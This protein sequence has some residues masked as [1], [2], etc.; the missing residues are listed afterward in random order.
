VSKHQ[1][2]KT[3]AV[4]L[5]LAIV[6]FTLCLSAHSDGREGRMSSSSS[7]SFGASKGGA[8]SV[9]QNPADAGTSTACVNLYTGQ[10][11]E[12]FP[13]ISLPGRVGT[14]ISLSLDYNGNVSRQVKAEN[15]ISQASDFGLGFTLGTEAIVADH[16]GTADIIDDEYRLVSGSSMVRL[17]SRGEGT[18]ITEDGRPWVITRS[19]ARAPFHSFSLPVCAIGWTIV[20]E[21]GSVYKYGDFDSTFTNRNATHYLLRFGTFVGP[22]YTP[23]D[24]IHAVQW[25]LSSMQSSADPT[26]RVL[27]SYTQEV[28]R[29]QIGRTTMGNQSTFAYTSASHLSY[30]LTPDGNRVDLYYSARSD[31]TPFYGPENYEMFSTSKCDSILAKHGSGSVLARILLGYS[32]L[33]SS[34]DANLG[35]P[36]QKLILTSICNGSTTDTSKQ[37][38]LRFDY[39]SDDT[40]QSMGSISRIIYPSGGVKEIDYGQ[41]SAATSFARLDN[42]LVS[43]ASTATPKLQSNW[44]AGNLTVAHVSDSTWRLAIWDGYWKAQDIKASAGWGDRAGVSADGWAVVPTTGNSLIICRWKG[45]YWQLDTLPNCWVRIQ[46]AFP[47][48]GKDGFVL[49][50]G[51]A[52]DNQSQY[53]SAYFF[54]WDGLRWRHWLAD[55]ISYLGDRW[56]IRSV[57]VKNDAFLISRSFQVDDDP[58]YQSEVIWGHIQGHFPN[59]TISVQTYWEPENDYIIGGN[60]SLGPDYVAWLHRDS[61][62]FVKWSGTA[63]SAP[64]WYGAGNMS[65]AMGSTPRGPVAQRWGAPS[66]NVLEGI[67]PCSGTPGYQVKTQLLSCTGIPVQDYWVGQLFGSRIGLGIWYVNGGSD[68]GNHQIEIWRAT[69]TGWM[70]SNCVIGG[71][72]ASS[73]D[74][75][76]FD[77]SYAFGPKYAGGEAY[78]VRARKYVGFG[79]ESNGWSN[80]TFSLTTRRRHDFAAGDLMFMCRTGSSAHF[81]SSQIYLSNR[82]YFGESYHPRTVAAYTSSDT[83]LLEYAVSGTQ[84][85]M[86]ELFCDTVSIDYGHGTHFQFPTTGRWNLNTYQLFDTLVMGKA[87][88]PVVNAVKMYLYQTDPNPTI[89]SF[90]YSAGLLDAALTTPRFA[91]AKASTPYFASEGSPV[92]W[93][94]HRFYNDID[95][96]GFYNDT[97]YSVMPFPNLKDSLRYGIGN[98]GYRLDGH[99]YFSAYYNTSDSTRLLDS[100][101]SFYSLA[102]VGRDT[103]YDVYRTQLNSVW[104]QSDSLWTY[105]SF[106]YDSANGQPCQTSTRYLYPTPADW[107]L[108]DSTVYAY[109]SNDSMKTD[110]ALVQPSSQLKILRMGSVDSVLSRSGADYTRIKRWIPRHSYVYENPGQASG[111]RYSDSL[112]TGSASCDSYGNVIAQADALGTLHASKYDRYG[113]KVVA[114]A[115]NCYPDGFTVLDLEQ[116]TTWDGWHLDSTTVSWID[117]TQCF[118]GHK[119][120]RMKDLVGTTDWNLGPTRN[121][122]KAALTSKL[123]YF[124]GWVKTDTTVG[125]YCYPQD[126]TNHVPSGMSIKTRLFSSHDGTKW[127]RFEGVFDLTDIWAGI[128]HIMIQFVMED[129]P[130]SSFAYFDDFR[131]H[132]IV[133]SVASSVYDGATGQTLASAGANNVPTST[134][135]DGFARPVTSKNSYGQTL[136]TT[137]Y[138]LPAI[139]SVFRDSALVEDPYKDTVYRFDT[140]NAS[141]MVGYTLRLMEQAVPQ[142]GRACIF[143]N[144]VKIDSLVGSTDGNFV[145]NG[146]FF[147]ARGDVI[148]LMAASAIFSQRPDMI[149]TLWRYCA[150]LSYGKYIYNP[151][152]P[153]YT[154]VTSYH[155]GQTPDTLVTYLDSWGRQL[156]TRGSDSLGDSPHA[157]VSGIATYDARGRVLKS[158]LPYQD[159]VGQSGV[160]NYSPPSSAAAEAAA[161]YDGGTLHGPDAQG[162]PY[163]ENAYTVEFNSKLQKAGSPGALFALNTTGHY[164]T[165]SSACRRTDR[166]AMSAAVDEDGL[167]DSTIADQF[168]LWS[169]KI[170]PYRTP[171]GTKKICIRDTSDIAHLKSF[172]YLDSTLDAGSTATPILL[173]ASFKNSLGLEDSTIKADYGTVQ[174]LYDRAGHLR[175]MRNDLR[176][177]QGTT[178]YFKYDVNGRKIEEGMV[179][180][181]DLFNQ[182]AAD[183]P[184]RPV[185]GEQQT[186]GYRWYYDRFDTLGTT[187]PLAPG[188][189]VRV[190]SGPRDYY[191]NYYYFG[192]DSDM[193][194]VKLPQASGAQ[195]AIKHFYNRDG[196][197]LETTVYPKYPD[198]SGTVPRHFATTYDAAGRLRDI[199]KRTPA[200]VEALDSLTY[201]AYD[202][203]PNGSYGTIS[204]GVDTNLEL[205]TSSLVQSVKY[206]Y[207]TRGQLIGIN[208]D[209]AISHWLAG[210]VDH[211]GMML[212]SYDPDTLKYFNGRIRYG[213][214]MNSAVGSVIDSN[215]FKY[216]YND[217]GWLTEARDS[218]KPVY[219]Q[220]YWYNALGQR[221]QLV[222]FDANGQKLDSINY[223]Y[224]ST[225]SGS[226]RLLS[227]TGLSSPL[228]YDMLGN[229]TS[230]VSRGIYS[231][232]YDYRNLMT[233]ASVNTNAAGAPAGSVV[234]SYDENEQRTKK[235][236]TYSYQAPCNVDDTS[237]VWDAM[238]GG[239]SSEDSGDVASLGMR[240]GGAQTDGSGPPARQCWYPTSAGTYYLYD[241]TTLVATFDQNDN[242][243]DMF[244]NG[245]SGR[246]ATYHQND[247][248][249]LYY[250]LNDQVGSTRVVM[251]GSGTVQVAEYYNY[252]PF[253]EPTESWGNFATPYQ[254]TSKEHDQNGSFDYVYFGARY[255]DPRVGAFASVDKAGQFASGYVYGANNPIMGADPDGNF[256]FLAA[257]FLWS[258]VTGAL[259]SSAAY[260]GCAAA[261]GTLNSQGFLRGLAMAAVGGALGSGIGGSLAAAGGKTAGT[262]LY[263]AGSNMATNMATSAV[264]QGKVSL[265]GAIGSTVGALA[266]QATFGNFHPTGNNRLVNVGENIGWS[267]IKGTYSAAISAEV[268][269]ALY[270]REVVNVGT[271][272]AG[273]AIG[274]ASAAGVDWLAYGAPLK[275]PDD[276]V[277]EVALEDFLRTT[278]TARPEYRTGGLLRLIY[279][280][281]S[282]EATAYFDDVTGKTSI[283]D[284]NASGTTFVHE[285]VHKW[286]LRL[287]GY[288]NER[289]AYQHSLAEAQRLM[290]GD[291]LG[292]YKLFGSEEWYAT[293]IARYYGQQY[294][295][296]F[297]SY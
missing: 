77:D 69:D 90:A 141:Q 41:M 39:Y 14:G 104:R 121:V 170:T 232:S 74:F 289:S 293:Q 54:R 29:L 296:T 10:H 68:Y 24:T 101:W 169:R 205:Q 234:C 207:D 179:P 134:E 202:Y 236:Y 241:G 67:Y 190:E 204:L 164:K 82:Y 86:K 47:F 109:R 216:F 238:Q 165:F 188:R 178:V 245:P 20:H 213:L 252:S 118:T 167:I 197:L 150:V 97:A 186:I 250:Y 212:G 162:Y 149:D 9:L 91:L 4:L 35:R 11:T 194:V 93:S 124:S 135:Y 120:L 92:G 237:I 210:S 191:R 23:D 209:N 280:Y 220:R 84:G 222:T 268:T 269:N 244:V 180:S 255:Y 2:A 249:K 185:S 112:L 85:V 133:S 95:T 158:Y 26:T 231:L 261:S 107:Y 57:Q 122:P 227:W 267:A 290:P 5:Q 291:K 173:R 87:L 253:G 247:D 203:N 248:S 196:S 34:K 266:T 200:G 211:F 98:G 254:F 28:R 8:L 100:V 131:F 287:W 159:I 58:H 265:A 37:Q 103:L 246:I 61:V 123:F 145:K 276:P 25:D 187:L 233:V 99:E 33:N 79:Y 102:Q 72:D 228:T 56:M 94:V 137:S 140:L 239:G 110:N 270:G 183:D 111:K 125:L 43:N 22:G 192:V 136:A 297:Y 182:A 59:D 217:L 81:D 195:K 219:S 285:A 108:I 152:E 63:W 155:S 83:A 12:T 172:T 153:A 262:F 189:L 242:V 42:R 132:P 36:F 16:A 1:F 154:A 295:L 198:S 176:R 243:I 201:A 13:L 283:L 157:V 235:V 240:G 144:G 168:G 71:A 258:V 65:N 80:I 143:K 15:R 19:V 48:V 214:S 251:Q 53:K 126:S 55:Q 116:G 184:S 275:G 44:T 181:A 127:Q 288:K 138:H 226:S 113:V 66:T 263:S 78:T 161:Y 229:L 282:S 62:C 257:P 166:T 45:G 17:I 174:M 284:R 215:Y 230:D 277:Q 115:S 264:L 273:G 163:S 38:P 206:K 31:S 278:G 256:F 3:I 175:F 76:L 281:S 32:Y 117:G 6:Q 18:Y 151:D 106:K 259:T 142:R 160:L 193:V 49:V 221:K 292:I 146:Q 46:A 279:G 73:N 51:D 148:K 223:I 96:S 40:C 27:L 70:G 225:S 119:S 286:L 129:A 218:T 199:H 30:L 64:S 177:L 272:C 128:D 171:T 156:Q 139:F 105:T 271:A 7:V 88:S 208:R 52:E 50:S 294:G 21:D 147:A 130:A 114:S 260:V 75:N 274:G 60:A 224:D 89:Q